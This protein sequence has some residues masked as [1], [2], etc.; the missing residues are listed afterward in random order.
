MARGACAV[1]CGQPR[2]RRRRPLV[3]LLDHPASGRESPPAPVRYRHEPLPL[4]SALDE[5]CGRSRELAEWDMRSR[6]AHDAG[7]GRLEEQ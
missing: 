4:F 5:G 7:R 3:E 1:G 6:A 2:R